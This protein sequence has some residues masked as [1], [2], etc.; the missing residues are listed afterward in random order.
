VVR[1]KRIPTIRGLATHAGTAPSDVRA[2]RKRL[3]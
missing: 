2:A 3:E 1:F